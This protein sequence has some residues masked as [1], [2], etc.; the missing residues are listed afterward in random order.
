MIEA[1][2][3]AQIGHVLRSQLIGRIACCDGEKIYVVP[4]TYV[5]DGK[6][7][8]AHSKEGQKIEIMRK[9]PQVCF[10]VDSIDNPTNWRCVMV[11]GKFH[12]LKD[13]EDQEKALLILKE[14]LMPF[15]LSETMKPKG[16]DHGRK[17]VE[18]EK[19]PVVYRIQIVSMTG[20]YE[21]V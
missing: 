1:L 13:K 8:Y 15:R 6:Y 11:H 5:F 3:Q 16:L 21:K 18:K 19:R 7:I 14:R 20:R 9:H 4:I 17:I 2:T 12:E 10:E